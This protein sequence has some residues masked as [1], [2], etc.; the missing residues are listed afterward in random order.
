M[1]KSED[2]KKIEQ[3]KDV[4]LKLNTK[5][6]KISEGIKFLNEEL[7]HVGIEVWVKTPNEVPWEL[8]YAKTDGRW[9]L[10]IRYPAAKTE[11]GPLL[12]APRDVRLAAVLYLSELLENMRKEVVRMNEAFDNAS[13]L[14]QF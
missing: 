8:G 14:A 1:L 13:W 10:A 5:A 6:S 3:I 4:I 2:Q 7:Q 12:L 9:Q 11:P